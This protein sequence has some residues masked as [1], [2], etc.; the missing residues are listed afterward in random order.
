MTQIIGTGSCI[1]DRCVRN[2]ELSPLVG[3][4]PAGIVRRT[5][6]R[7]RRWA[8]K[9]QASSDL[10]ATA[11]REALKNARRE[12]ESLDAIILATT[13]P[14]MLFPSTACLVQRELGV[15]KAFAFDI[16]ASCAGF[17]FALSIAR[18]M[19]ENGGVRTAAVVAAEIKSRFLDFKD[20]ATA[21]IFGDGAGAV[22]LEKG[23]ASR[24]IQDIRISS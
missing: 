23:Q 13:S 17:L 21:V 14:D 7:E 2:E 6:I 16:S 12:P 1:P 11:V 15:G 20:A 8:E 3:L 4:S 10:A 19:I 24:G 5:G 9:D 18:Q 22:I